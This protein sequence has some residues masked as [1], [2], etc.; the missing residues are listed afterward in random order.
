NDGSTVECIADATP[1]TPPTIVDANGDDVIPVMTENA[2]PACEG[3]KIYTFTYTDCAGNTGVWVYT[4]TIDVV[5]NPV[6]PTNDGSTVECIADATQP[7]APVVTDVCGNAITPVITENTDPT[8]EGDKIYTFTYTDCAGNESVYVYTYTID[9][10]T[11][12]VV[13]TND[14]STVECIADAT[15]PTAP[16]VTDVCGNAI[17]PVITENTDPTCEGDKI[18]TF[19]YTDCAGNESV[20]VYTYTIDVSTA[21]VVPTNDGSTVECIADAT[22]PTAPVVTDVCGNAI[23]P[24]ITENTDP[25]CEGDK[26]YTFTYTDCAGNESVYVYTYTIDVSTAPVVPTNDGSTVECIADATQPTAPVVTDVCGNAITPVI[27]E[28]TDPVCEGDKIYTFTYTDCAGNISVYNYT[29]TVKDTTAPVLTLPD[30][31]TAECSDDLTPISFGEATAT[32]N[33]DPNPVITFND[34][35]TNGNC[36]GSFTITRTWTATDACGNAASANQII[37][38]SDTTAP[39][40]D[41]TDLPGDIVVECD[42]IPGEETLT[43][44]DNCG[45]AIVTVSDERIDRNCPNNYVIKRSYTAT[46]DCGVTNT[47]VQT[48]TVQDSTPP[49]FVETLPTARIVAECDNIPVAETLTATDTCGSAIVTVSDARTDDNCPNNYTLARTWT[50]TD[51]CG[52]TTTHTQIIIVR[53]TTAPT[54]VET[55]PRDTTVECDDIPNATTLTA[56]DNCGN[57]TVAVSDSRTDDDC[58]SN[59]T[60]ARTWIA[61][62]GCGLTTTHTQLIT[63]RDTTAPV[64]VSAF[65][66]TLDVS[67]TDIPEAPEVE[68]TDNCSANV[69]VVFNET[70]TFDENVIADY[71]IIRTWTVRDACNNEEVYTQTLNVALDEILNEVVAEDRCFEDGVVNL[72]NYLADGTFGG[73]WELIEGNPVATVTGSIFDPTNLG[74]DYSESF[75]PNT[76]GIEYVLRYTGFQ[77]GCINI[78]DVIMVIDAKC[79]VLPC[80]KKDISIST[81]ITPNG[82]DFNKTFDIEGITLCG[83]V[84]EVKIFNRWGALVYESNDYTLGSERDGDG[85][86]TDSGFGKWDGTSPK[87]AIGNNGK[88]PNGTYYYIINLRNSGLDPITGPVYLGTK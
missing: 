13:P 43:A 47:H 84:A 23:T 17:T 14:G 73:T 46:D 61:T 44:T 54:F 45:N 69:I 83:F 76:D 18:Y 52:L 27:T 31:V 72:D 19:T 51:A 56:V 50:A 24:V 57:A 1:P 5:T 75:N 39:E 34:V 33:C 7:T 68:F 85:F 12:P 15:Q 74:S 3:D 20:Y 42:G 78:T 11:A 55:L 35:T 48:I 79:R 2:D 80:G 66:E 36:P 64:P 16:V 65:E 22:Q 62:D 32:D 21:P 82:D 4:Y 10:S 81:A 49:A 67:C 58:P 63:V 30:N 77:D 88:L 71:Q 25:T 87:S 28:N 9:V 41:Q 86:G 70:N 26:I 29:Y 37:S 40:F 8:C 6:V 53:D 60:I 38:T 59:Y